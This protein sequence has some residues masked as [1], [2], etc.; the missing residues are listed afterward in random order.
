MNARTLTVIALLLVA[1]AT[2][3]ATEGEVVSIQGDLLSIVI[4]TGP[5]PE[6]GD[7]ATVMNQPDANGNA[8]AAGEWR[9][10]KVRG[11]D[12]TANLVRRFGG[13][14]S[15]GLEV[16]FR[17]SGGPGLGEGDDLEVPGTT[18]SGIP[19]KV[20]EVRDDVVTIR[21]EQEVLDDQPSVRPQHARAA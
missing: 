12:V 9:V 21:L 5:P 6:V 3:H 8:T 16:H 19:G 2:S 15:E 1:F 18:S 10:T 14:A 20:T 4:Q 11:T 17:S 13:E 7:T